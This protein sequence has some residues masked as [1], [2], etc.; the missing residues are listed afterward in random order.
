MFWKWRFF[1]F[2]LPD[3]GAFGSDFD[4]IGLGSV[5]LIRNGIVLGSVLKGFPSLK[6]T[7]GLPPDD[8]KIIERKEMD[9]TITNS[10]GM[11]FVLIPSGKFIM[12]SPVNETG[13]RKNEGPQHGVQISTPSY[14]GKYEVKVSEFRQFVRVT[15]YKTEAEKAGGCLIQKNNN[16]EKGKGIHWDNPG[17]SQNDDHPVTCVSWNDV[18]EFCRWLAI[19]TGYFYRLPTEAEWE[20]ACR[21]GDQKAFSFGSDAKALGTYAWYSDNAGGRTHPVGQMKPNDWGLYDMQGNVREWCQDWYGEYT[22]EFAVDP[23]G[24]DKGQ[25]R[26]RRGGAWGAA[27][28]DCRCGERSSGDPG[29]ALFR[30]GFR[31]VMTNF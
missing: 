8:K 10:M 23:V 3:R 4:R 30:V 12:G 29:T 16:W 27:A 5:F 20:Y 6:K 26:I 18:I 28:K 17:F 24:P 2:L 11:E 15:G 22:S 7:P 14:M 13:R 9:K 31:L 1:K 19:K 25:H 21:A